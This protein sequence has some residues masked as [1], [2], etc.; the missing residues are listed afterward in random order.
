MLSEVQIHPCVSP[1]S[2]LQSPA[3]E[4]LEY[5]S[6]HPNARDTIEGIRWWVLDACIH[7]CMRK[8]APHIAEAVAQ[9]VELKFLEQQQLAD[10]R[11]FYRISARY[12]ADL[13][14]RSTSLSGADE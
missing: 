13:Q 14:K 5:F 3:P 10:G 12:L 2:S 11:I 6:R 1:N 8:S 9:L 7:A 4:I